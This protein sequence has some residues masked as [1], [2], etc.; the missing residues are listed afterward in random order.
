MNKT[1][2]IINDRGKVG[3]RKRSWKW[4]I[5]NEA[6]EAELFIFH[7]TYNSWVFFP[8]SSSQECRI[9]ESWTT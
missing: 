5:G 4:G 2:T 8:L 9:Q 6:H 7:G 1:I 3:T